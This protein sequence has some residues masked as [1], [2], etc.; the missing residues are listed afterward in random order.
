MWEPEGLQS[1]SAGP[2]MASSSHWGVTQQ[3]NTPILTV[4]STDKLGDG[5]GDCGDGDGDG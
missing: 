3:R 4:A 5:D 1:T 2:R